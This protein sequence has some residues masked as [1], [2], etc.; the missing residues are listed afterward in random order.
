M[1]F[2]KIILIICLDQLFI[3]FVFYC[4]WR[5]L[6]FVFSYKLIKLI[7][8]YINIQYNG[9]FNNYIHNSSKN[10]SSSIY[11][12]WIK[13]GFFIKDGGLARPLEI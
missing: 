13:S 1:T 12:Y 8:I 10:I 11:S 7:Y 4:V 2:V 6:N 5:E 9:N 3:E